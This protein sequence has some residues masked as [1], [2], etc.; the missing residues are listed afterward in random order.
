[1][2]HNYYVILNLTKQRTNMKQLSDCIEE[3]LL[4]GQDRTIS[5]GNKIADDMHKLHYGYAYMN[6]LP[7]DEKRYIA[8]GMRGIYKK[9]FISSVPALKTNIHSILPAHNGNLKSI[10][11]TYNKLDLNGDY[12]AAYI[13]QVELDDIIE[14]YDFIDNKNDGKYL[15][16]K[17]N[18]HLAKILNKDGKENLELRITEV[19]GRACPSDALK[20][21]TVSLCSKNEDDFKPGRPWYMKGGNI[22]LPLKFVKG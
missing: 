12:L 21:L 18:D 20:V 15:E 14:S 1:M 3:G 4:K 22:L 17:L 6:N 16:K 8:G 11:I 7:W 5:S 10:Y 9:Y 2:N 13:L 19:H